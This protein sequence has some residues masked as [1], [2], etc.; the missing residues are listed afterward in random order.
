MTL[1]MSHK[2]ILQYR[3]C[4]TLKGTK[5]QSN[6]RFLKSDLL[7]FIETQ[8]HRPRPVNGNRARKPRPV[9]RNGA[10]KHGL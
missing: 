9:N 4:G 3:K 5:I 10:G 1:Q 2:T 7:A 8:D 6:V